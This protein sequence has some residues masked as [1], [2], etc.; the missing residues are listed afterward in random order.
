MLRYDP[1]NSFES[2]EPQRY[3][4]FLCPTLKTYTTKSWS[5]I[6]YTIRYRPCLTRY[7]SSPVSF[8]QRDGL[9][10]SASLAILDTMRWRSFLLGI[11][12]IS[13]T[14][15]GLIRILYRATS[16][17]IFQHIFECQITFRLS[18]FK[19]GQIFFILCQA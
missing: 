1:E 17:K 7:F 14:A 16:L 2:Q 10:L 15:E 3:M 5:S 9:G 6:K 4:S 19:C 11:R 13:L 12:S 8:S 18:L